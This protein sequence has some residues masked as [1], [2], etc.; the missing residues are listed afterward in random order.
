M[1]K[2]KVDAGPTRN[3]IINTITKDIRVQAAIFDLIDNSINAAEVLANPKRLQQYYVS[4]TIGSTKFEITDNCGGIS[5]DKVLGDALKIGS[6]L[7]YKGGH[8]VGLKRAFLKFGKTIEIIS[9]RSDYS[10]KAEI[11]VEQWGKKNDWYIDIEKEIYNESM[12]QGLTITVTN[13]YDDI[14]SECFSKSKFLYELA[15]E[16]GVRYRYKLQT[17]FQIIVNGQTVKPILVDGNKI[18][19][20]PYRVINGMTTKIILYNNEKTDK[21]GW[22][23]IVNGRVTLQRDKSEKTSWKRIKKNEG[24]SYASFVGEVL[25]EGDN[26]K[27]LPIYSTKDDIDVNSKAYQDIL[28]YMY[29]F[30]NNHKS[31]FK[32]AETIIQYSRPIH[33]I[34]RLKEYFDAKT[35]KEV[36][37]TSFDYTYNSKIRKK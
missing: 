8:G 11:D 17:G 13:L 36:G 7:E 33:L 21:N 34:E 24:C 29:W 16:I 30:L 31:E 1:K 23:I 3:F 4:L 22:D 19:E 12:P 25:V 5:E 15:E 26:I 35:A 10:C 27:K 28:D 9:N 20:S 37:E 18:A 14:I 2:N 32:K 6:S